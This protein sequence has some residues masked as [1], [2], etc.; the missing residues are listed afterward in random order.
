[1]TEEQIEIPNKEFVVPYEIL[2]RRNK[3]FQRTEKYVA[4]QGS[5]KPRED[6]AKFIKN[7]VK[8]LYW[9]MHNVHLDQLEWALDSLEG[10]GK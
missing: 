10:E 5:K 3:L 2:I 9:N 7:T 1:M 6:A 4:K 8:V